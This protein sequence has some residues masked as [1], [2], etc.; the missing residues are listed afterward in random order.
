[1]TTVEN[2]I[3]I[4]SKRNNVEFKKILETL[5]LTENKNN[6]FTDKYE[7][8]LENTG[9]II[10]GYVVDFFMN[11]TIT[12]FSFVK[13]YFEFLFVDENNN[14]Y[15]FELRD[16][17]TTIIQQENLENFCYKSYG[18]YNTNLNLVF[19]FNSSKKNI[20]NVELDVLKQVKEINKNLLIGGVLKFSVFGKYIDSVKTE[21]L[22]DKYS[23]Y[24]LERICD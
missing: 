19:D 16:F 14:F 2:P 6:Y 20:K 12:S 23:S 3:K 21:N 7:I 24:I 9:Q 15:F 13:K 8:Y 17:Y 11:K 4:F 22:L 10:R 5:N 18:A 1:M